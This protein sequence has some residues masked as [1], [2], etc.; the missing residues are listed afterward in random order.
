M[1]VQATGFGIMGGKPLSGDELRRAN[2][3]ES[4]FNSAQR[5]SEG[6]SEFD[7]DAAMS[8]HHFLSGKVGLT[9]GQ[10][11]ALGDFEREHANDTWGRYSRAFRETMQGHG[12]SDSQIEQILDF[13][14][15]TN[16]G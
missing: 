15:K 4:M 2:D 5:E 10:L 8:G 3:Y 11:T 9:S 7:L 13:D 14:R 12:L 1:D 16:W 6:Q